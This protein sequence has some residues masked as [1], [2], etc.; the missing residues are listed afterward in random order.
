MLTRATVLRSSYPLWNASVQNEGGAWQFSPIR[1]KN[2]LPQQRPLN[3][4]EKKVG[5]IMPTDICTYPENLVKVGLE[6]SE[7]IGLQG[8]C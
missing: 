6:H 2:W 5:L 7:T 4:R 3:D 1:A 8:D